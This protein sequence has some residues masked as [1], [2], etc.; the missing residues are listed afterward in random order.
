MPVEYTVDQK[1]VHA[2]GTA[3][4]AEADGKQ[5]R[6]DLLRELREV[7]KPMV[8]ELQSAVRAIP[9]ATV[10]DP[11]L[12]D[13]IAGQVKVGA[14]MSGRSTGLQV[15]VSTKKDPRGFRFA[16][17]R[18]NSRRGWRHPVFGRDTWVVQYGREWF[19]PTILRHRDDARAAILAA[20]DAM[21]RRIAERAQKESQ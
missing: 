10:A 12:R 13:A 4:A 20:V 1:A 16:A 19:E 14:R 2:I 5:L 8:P 7:G 11:P 21:A 17:R 9:A 18:L 15:S 6:R 3:M